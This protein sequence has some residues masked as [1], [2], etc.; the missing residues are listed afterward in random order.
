MKGEQARL[1]VLITLPLQDLEV[2][3]RKCCHMSCALCSS[4]WG[5]LRIVCGLRSTGLII[6]VVSWCAQRGMWL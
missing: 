2:G 3:E 6:M 4:G 1:T 5:G